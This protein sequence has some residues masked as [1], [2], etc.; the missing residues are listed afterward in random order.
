M[1]EWD[2]EVTIRRDGNEVGTADVL[3]DG[4]TD[5]MIHAVTSELA[6]WARRDG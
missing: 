1:S 3:A 6:D 5:D 4:T 2:I